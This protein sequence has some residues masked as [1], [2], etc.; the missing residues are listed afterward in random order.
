MNK[1]NGY[2]FPA[3]P[4]GIKVKYWGSTE[5]PR[6]AGRD[7]NRA[8]PFGLPNTPFSP[9]SGK[10]LSLDSLDDAPQDPNDGSVPTVIENNNAA[11]STD[12]SNLRTDIINLLNNYIDN[13]VLTTAL[14]D[15]VLTT[16]LNSAL[17]NYTL[18]SGLGTAF[19]S[20]LAGLP[21]YSASANQALMNDNGTLKWVTVQECS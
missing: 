11:T 6:S 16:A 1:D 9:S 4:P 5:P 15:Y 20:Y 17:E 2:E 21:G 14:G 8:R 12:V 10:F 3:P 13:T 7:P 19:A 18:T